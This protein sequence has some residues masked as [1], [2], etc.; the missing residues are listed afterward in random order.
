MTTRSSENALAAITFP[1][2]KLALW[3]P[4][5]NG[6]VISLHLSYYRNPRLLLVESS[7]FVPPAFPRE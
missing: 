3:D 7:S 4:T 5:S 2:S 6:D 1:K